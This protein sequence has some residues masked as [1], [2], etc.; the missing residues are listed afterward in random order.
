MPRCRLENSAQ[1]CLS[2]LSSS[3]DNLKLTGRNLAEFSTLDLGVLVCP[4]EKCKQL[5][6]YQ[7]FLLLRDIWWSKF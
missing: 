6:E 3:I 7:N 2:R 1:V 5:L 4:I